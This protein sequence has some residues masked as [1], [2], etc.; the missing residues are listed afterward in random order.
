MSIFWG[1]KEFVDYTDKLFFDTRDGAR[2][3][4]PTKIISAISKLRNMHDIRF[5]QFVRVKE[6][7]PPF[8][9]GSKKS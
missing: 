4:F 2:Q 3:G 5:P 6:D 1:S 9:F 8:T 7:S